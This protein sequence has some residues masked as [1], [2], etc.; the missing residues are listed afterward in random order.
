ME[1]II[2]RHALAEE[3]EDFAKKGLEDQFRPLTLKGR[4]R[5]QKVCMRMKDFIKDVDVIVTSPFTRAAQTAQILS[6]FYPGK[7]VIEIP[8]MVP[9]SPPQA[10]L[11]WFR[12]QGRNHKK[13][14]IVGHEP[15]LSV[16]ASYML[17][18]KAESF[19]DLRKS[20]VLSLELESFAQANAG[21]AELMYSIPPKIFD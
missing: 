21:G 8:E 15:H 2:V 16:F 18:G 1:I 11:K 10:L 7:K 19:I 9:Q 17:T 3:R 5:M 4:K 13:I 12:T 20:G 14:M 6:Q